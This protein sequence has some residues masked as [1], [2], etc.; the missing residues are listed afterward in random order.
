LDATLRL[1]AK[2]GSSAAGDSMAPVAT[3]GNRLPAEE[4][5]NYHIIAVGRP[6]RNA[7]IRQVN[8]LLPQPFLPGS[9][10]IDQR[11]DGVVFRLP[12]GIDLGYAQLIHSPWNQTRALLATTGTTDTAIQWVTDVLAGR[13]WALR[14]GDLALVQGDEV[15][16]IATHKL[17]HGGKAAA[18]ATAVPDLIPVAKPTATTPLAVSLAA[19]PSSLGPTSDTPA[20]K[21]SLKETEPPDW[22]IPLVGTTIV[23]VIVILGIAL[24]QARWRASKRGK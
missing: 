14:S 20:V 11:L 6:S 9:D 18:V 1:V 13:P 8:A 5:A 21:P 15:N 19:T 3:L 17:T 12:P 7:L 4:L 16:T 23:V 22:L 10:E 2:L 24:W